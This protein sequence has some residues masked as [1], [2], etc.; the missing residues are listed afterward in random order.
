MR[1]VESEPEIVCMGNGDGSSEKER[2]MYD[3]EP[4]DKMAIA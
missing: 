4:E 1:R 2:R 3:G